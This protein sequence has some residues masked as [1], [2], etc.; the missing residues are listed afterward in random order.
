MFR[1]GSAAGSATDDV[2]IVRQS[3]KL[4]YMSVLFCGFVWGM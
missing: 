2:T 3:V 1:G 4:Y